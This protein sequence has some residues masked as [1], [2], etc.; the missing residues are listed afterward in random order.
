MC[1][2][3]PLCVPTHASGSEHAAST[4]PLV[5]CFSVPPGF[6]N[7]WT[8]QLCVIVMALETALCL[9]LGVASLPAICSL[10]LPWPQ[11]PQDLW[12]VRVKARTADC[13]P[14]A[15]CTLCPNRSRLGMGERTKISYGATW[16]LP[17][18]IVIM[19]GY[20]IFTVYHKNDPFRIFL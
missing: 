8:R 13:I 5:P 7:A 20:F 4:R 15:R 14:A 1:V 10:P 6:N 16:Y 18:R 12:A 2:C 19:T 17:S 3:L 9:C 11:T